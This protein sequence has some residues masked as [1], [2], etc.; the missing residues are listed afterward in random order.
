MWR[1][2][3]A[4]PQGTIR[5]KEAVIRTLR[6]ACV[7]QETVEVLEHVLQDPVDLDRDGDLL[8]AH[9]ISLDGLIDR[10]GGSP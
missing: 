9:G 4:R 10:V 8:L 7:G 2:D 3:N 5:S 6:R 1:D